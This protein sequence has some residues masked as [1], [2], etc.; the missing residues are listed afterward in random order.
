[1]KRAAVVLVLAALAGASSLVAAHEGHVHKVMGTV[2]AITASQ[3]EVDTK[4]AGKQTYAL[5]KQTVYRRGKASAAAS[6]VKVGARVVLSVVE[7]H[8][9][10]NVTEV[11]MAEAPPAR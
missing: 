3:I 2:A 11:L 1:M 6:D 5:T 8:G 10:K 4:D 7:E 9:V